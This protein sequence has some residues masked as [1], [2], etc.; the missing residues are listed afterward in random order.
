MDNRI[1]T[2]QCHHKSTYIR[3]RDKDWRE[4]EERHIVLEKLTSGYIILKKKMGGQVR[5]RSCEGPTGQRE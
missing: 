2:I 1:L 3:S 5:E 4:D